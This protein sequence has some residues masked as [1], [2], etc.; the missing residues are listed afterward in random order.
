MARSMQSSLYLQQMLIPVYS[1][2][3]PLLPLPNPL[4]PSS[5]F[6]SFLLCSNLL[7]R[8]AVTSTF[9]YHQTSARAGNPLL[10]HPPTLHLFLFLRYPPSFSTHPSST[11]HTYLTPLFFFFFSPYFPPLV[12]FLFLFLFLT[13]SGLISFA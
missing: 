10:R 8:S 13:G 2:S 6:L 11:S 3:S 5:A 12:F 4:L 7:Y 1:P 9:T